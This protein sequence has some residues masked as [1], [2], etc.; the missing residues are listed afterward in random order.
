MARSLV[1]ARALG[2][3]SIVAA[4]AAAWA[5]ASLAGAPISN[6][7]G[8]PWADPAHQ[9]QLEL[10]ASRV[11]SSL[12]G[13]LVAVQCESPSSWQTLARELGFD[14]V[15]ELGYVPVSYDPTGETVLADST[16]VELAPEV[17]LHLQAFAS[18][19]PK[20]TTCTVVTTRRE[21]VTQCVASSSVSGLRSGAACAYAPFGASSPSGRR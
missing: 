10:L 9:G 7:A 21:T 3:L 18:V 12:A 19:D 17:C 11:A 16:V 20:P 1:R 2:T 4:V 13:R 6:D 5:S 8:L 14:P 15:A